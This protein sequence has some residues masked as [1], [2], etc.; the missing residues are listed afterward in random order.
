VE[1]GKALV[2]R[3]L[4]F[5]AGVTPKRHGSQHAGRGSR[6]ASTRR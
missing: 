4:A 5:R 2:N 6:R 3:M 1:L